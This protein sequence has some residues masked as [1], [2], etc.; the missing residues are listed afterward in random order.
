[1][2]IRNLVGGLLIWALAHGASEDRKFIVPRE[3]TLL[4]L[5]AWVVFF[6]LALSALLT[7]II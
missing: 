4:V 3:E 1:M 5:D 6:F 2:V 7:K